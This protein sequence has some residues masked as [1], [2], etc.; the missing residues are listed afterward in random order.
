MAVAIRQHWRS[1]VTPMA[2]SR[3]VPP[4]CAMLRISRPRCSARATS[5]LPAP[6]NAYVLAKHVLCAATE[7]PLTEAETDS[8]GVKEIV[9][10]LVEQGQLVDLP[11]PEVAWKPTDAVGDPYLDWSLHSASAGA[12]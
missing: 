5:C 10:R 4:G 1:G 6:T 12:I 3:A 9:A 7:Q 11:D 2:S 8:W